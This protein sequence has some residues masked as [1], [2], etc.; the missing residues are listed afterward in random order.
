M[1]TILWLALSS[2][3]LFWLRRWIIGQVQA[4]GY[5]LSGD[6]TVMMWIYFVVFLPGIVVHE[7]SHWL[8]ALLLGVSRG[9]IKIWPE[10]ARGGMR[11]GSVTI[12]SVD[13]L[14]NSLVGL[15]PLLGGSL[16][17]LLVGDWILG[18]GEVGKIIL[19]GRWEALG[20]LVM[21]YLHIPDFWLWLYLVFAVAT[22]MMPSESD[23]EPWPP[24]VIF[25][26]LVVL[27]VL[28]SGWTP[29]IGPELAEG[30]RSAIS[31]LAYTF[32]LA[33]GVDLVFGLAL[34]LLAQILVIGRLVI[35]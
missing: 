25:L 10:R 12:K 24:V 31:T 6:P 21:D 35:K 1:F 2:L 5:L 23:R 9:K 7:L 13:P 18:L 3:V 20:P 8:T 26:A 33:A 22:S 28:I 34:F 14:R 11:L 15:A 4:I 16:V 29:R 19:A 17:V 30:V 27:A 32:T